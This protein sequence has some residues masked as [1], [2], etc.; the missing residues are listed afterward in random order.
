M[1]C[2]IYLQVSDTF[3]RHKSYEILQVNLCV[4]QTSVWKLC[5]ETCC[6]KCTSDVSICDS[7]W[8]SEQS[9]PLPRRL[10]ERLFPD[11]IQPAGSIHQRPERS[12]PQEQCLFWGPLFARCPNQTQGHAHQEGSQETRSATGA[13]TPSH[14]AMFRVFNVIR[15]KSPTLV[16]Y[17]FS[18]CVIMI[19]LTT[20]SHWLSLILSHNP[21]QSTS[22]VNT[23]L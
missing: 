2:V 10:H 4:L 9:P 19:L 20:N 8:I 18:L 5:V 14:S 12:L 23:E 21:W 16:C 15:L 1:S 17:S 6:Y 3:S 13:A 22:Q 11:Q 7:H